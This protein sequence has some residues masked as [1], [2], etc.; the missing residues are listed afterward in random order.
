MF[1]P[2]SLITSIDS[3]PGWTGK[4]K[5]NWDIRIRQGGTETQISLLVP[6][7]SHIA[8]VDGT[9]NSVLD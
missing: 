5:V 3:Q 7:L 2:M 1:D 9:V 6:S 4:V 8:P